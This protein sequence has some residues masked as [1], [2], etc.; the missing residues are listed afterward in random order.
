MNKMG[1]VISK[2]YDNDNDSTSTPGNE[3]QKTLEKDQLKR[4][5]HKFESESNDDED[6]ELEQSFQRSQK[7]V[8]YSGNTIIKLDV[9]GTVFKT[10]LDTLTMYKH[11]F[12]DSMFC[13]RFP[14]KKE[15]SSGI[16]A[17]Y[18]GTKIDR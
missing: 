17:E 4:D 13:G 16:N 9:G 8:K 1:S 5:R 3:Q 12:F 7:W 6:G 2:E 18:G 15:V 11:S 14:L 10:T